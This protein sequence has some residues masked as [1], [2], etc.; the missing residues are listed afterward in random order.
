[1]ISVTNIVTTTK[2]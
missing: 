2:N 1:L